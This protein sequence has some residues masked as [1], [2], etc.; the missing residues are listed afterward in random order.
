MPRYSTLS[1]IQADLKAGTTSCVAIVDHYL[2][3]IEAH[4]ELNAYVEVFAEEAKAQ[5]KALDDKYQKNASSVGRLFGAVISIKDVLCYKDHSVTAASKILEGFESLFS[6]TAVERLLAEDAIIIGR[7]NCDEFAMGSTNESSYYGAT[8]NA[9]DT[10]KVPGGSSG[11]S[12]VAVQA[13]T[14]LFSLG[15]DTGGSVRQPAAF[16][17]VIGLKPSY[18]R[19]SRYGLLAY[20]SSFDQIGVFSHS[21]EDAALCLEIMAGSDEFD[22]SASTKEVPAYSQAL[23]FDK[24]SKIAYLGTALHHPSLDPE[25]KAQCQACIEKLEAEGHE[26]KEID[27]DLLDYIIPAYY[28]LTTAEASSNLS[29]YDGIRYGHRSQEAENLL[30]TYQKSRTE[31]FG[32]EVKRRIMLGTF[33]L[34]SGY[35]DAYYSKAQKVRR[36]IQQKTFEIFE[37]YDYIL[38][39]AAPGTAW[40]LGTQMDDPVA[41]YLADIFTVQ[42]NMVGIPGI[43]LPLGKHSNGLPIGIQ[44]MANKFKE[45][46][47]LAFS[48]YIMNNILPI[49]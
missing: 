2:Q 41:M 11:G 44:F 46:D 28:V 34:S 9:A 3:Q 14:C 18:G 22:A 5:A 45:A 7:T 19:V 33:V 37:S 26:V 27:F 36:L 48:D 47:L 38:M 15:T 49:K 8:K 23:Q 24:K 10:S 42:A 43:S 1:S 6:A 31:G 20:G 25:V 35:Y 32:K 29:R 21:V 40:D 16:C 4:Q 39:P 12:A 17:G 30:E 13:D